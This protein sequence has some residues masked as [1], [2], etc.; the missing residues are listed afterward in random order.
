MAYLRNAER[1]SPP[2][3]VS[4]VCRLHQH[5]DDRADQTTG[6]G[7]RA[8]TF[9]SAGDGL[10]DRSRDD[11]PTS[12]RRTGHAG[13]RTLPI[14]VEVAQRRGAASAGSGQGPGTSGSRKADG[15]DGVVRY[16]GVQDPNGEATG[17][18][19]QSMLQAVGFDV[20][21]NFVHSPTD[22]VK[23][24]YV[25]HDYDVALAGPDCSTPRPSCV[26][27]R[28]C[29]APRPTIRQASEALPSTRRWILSWRGFGRRQACSARERSAGLR[30]R[31][32]DPGVGRRPPISS[33]GRTTSSE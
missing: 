8:P 5:G 23:R 7:I 13:R 20:Q 18:A 14:L 25:D 4:R 27:T 16:V 15:Y 10:R 24:L 29:T 6:Q 32:P 9:E 21:L 26:C 17:L 30:R 1:Y 28:R 31:G 33:P 12:P 19:V 3:T 11:R 2:R 22:M